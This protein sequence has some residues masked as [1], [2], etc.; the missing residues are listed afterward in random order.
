MLDKTGQSS[1][2]PSTIGNQGSAGPQ[3]DG[4]CFE[5]FLVCYLVFEQREVH[6][7]GQLCFEMLKLSKDQESINRDDLVHFCKRIAQLDDNFVNLFYKKTKLDPR[8]AILQ[9]EFLEVFPLVSQ[10][11]LFTLI[12][13]LIDGFKAEH[14]NID[15]QD[16][17]KLEFARMKSMALSEI[18]MENYKSA[19]ER[20]LGL[21]SDEME[22]VREFFDEEIRGKDAEYVLRIYN[23]L[24]RDVLHSDLKRCLVDKITKFKG[25]DF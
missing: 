3:V 23:M 19:A 9:S 2:S 22:N 12:P 25:N 13:D 5:D 15:C 18:Q 21:G 10:L 20:D 11:S 4:M 16:D 24:L 14:L 1:L 7:V 17:T 8:I 6:D